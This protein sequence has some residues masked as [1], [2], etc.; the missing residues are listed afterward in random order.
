MSRY[1]FAGALETDLDRQGRFVLTPP[2]ITHAR[3]GRDVVV[4]GVRDH[5][6]I[7]EPKAWRAQLEEVEGS[8]ELV[9]ERLAAKHG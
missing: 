9:A 3:L 5:L 8:A 7:W 1:F 2:L 4:A 6:E